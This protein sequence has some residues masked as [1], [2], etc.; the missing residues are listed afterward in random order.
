M[1]RNLSVLSGKPA[2]GTLRQQLDQSDYINRKK[3]LYNFCNKKISPNSKKSCNIGK[4]IC[5][6]VIPV[7]K[8]NL[9]MGQYSKLDL[10]NVCDIIAGPP[11]VELGCIQSCPS[12]PVVPGGPAPFFAVYTI[13]PNGS[14]FGNNQC[15]SLN[16]THYLKFN[17][18]LTDFST[19]NK[20][21]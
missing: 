14:L 21:M 18:L 10:N 13:D 4:Y 8:G 5:P 7:N 2:F 17:P 11:C 12:I 3:G 15:G 20:I 19:H 9:I 6:Y 1:S 16:Y